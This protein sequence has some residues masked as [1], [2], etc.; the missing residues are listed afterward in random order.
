LTGHLTKDGKKTNGFTLIELMMVL[1]IIAIL[2][3]I[4]VPRYMNSLTKARE[5]AL[6]ENLFQMRDAI[7][8]YYADN[9]AYPESLMSLV[10]KK[11]VRSIPADPFTGSADTWVE[12]ES[13]DGSGIYD[14]HSG[15][16]LT[17][18]SGAPYGEW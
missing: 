6:L 17:G 15:S 1:A 10:D 4:A 14:V 3:S 9:G 8:K 2:L 11:Y 5:A 16:E 7:D 13:Q 12:V 18:R